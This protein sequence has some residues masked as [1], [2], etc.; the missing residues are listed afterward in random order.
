MHEK[1]LH[2]TVFRT[3][4]NTTLVRIWGNAL[5]LSQ[6]RSCLFDEVTSL[7]EADSVAFR[8]ADRLTNTKV[9]RSPSVAVFSG[10]LEVLN[11]L[12]FEFRH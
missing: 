6:V 2:P 7:V 3:L 1:G 5:I 12:L 11:R 8:V 10:A 9:V 4:H